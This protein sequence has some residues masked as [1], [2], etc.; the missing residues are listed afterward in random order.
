MKKIFLHPVLFL[1][2]SLTQLITLCG[3]SVCGSLPLADYSDESLGE[4]LRA[5]GGGHS[6]SLIYN[7]QLEQRGT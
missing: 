5:K 4:R 2:R 3:S 7:F 6:Q 1:A